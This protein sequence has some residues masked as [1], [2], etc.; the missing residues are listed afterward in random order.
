ML[1]ATPRRN[2]AGPSVRQHTLCRLEIADDGCGC[3]DPEG[4]GLRGMR[5]RLQTIGGSLER[6]TGQGTRL[7]IQLP[8]AA[9]RGHLGSR[10]KHRPLGR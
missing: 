10:W 5:E 1:C 8:L 7:V 6:L 4:N 3:D 2:A 9:G